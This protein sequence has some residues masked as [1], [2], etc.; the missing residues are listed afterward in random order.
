MVP[1][2]GVYP[3]RLSGQL[4]RRPRSGRT[5]AR[6]AID[7]FAH[8]GNAGAGGGAGKSDS[9]RP[10]PPGADAV[11]WVAGPPAHASIIMAHLNSFS[12]EE[13]ATVAAGDELGPASAIG[14]KR[15]CPRP[16]HLHFG[17][18]PLSHLLPRRRP[19]GRCSRTPRAP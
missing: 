3:E 1:V 13:G 19:C 4:R 8:R 11:V 9:S 2:A 12:V 6:G 16:P 15:P 10:Q 14:G 17:I 5:Q 7:I 18:Y